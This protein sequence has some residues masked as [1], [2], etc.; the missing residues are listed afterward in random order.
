MF[1]DIL[2]QENFLPNNIFL[3]QPAQTFSLL[4][5][6]SHFSEEYAWAISEY[7]VNLQKEVSNDYYIIYL[8]DESEEI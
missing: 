6:W 7:G 3:P 4:E 8:S 5:L 2:L 1:L